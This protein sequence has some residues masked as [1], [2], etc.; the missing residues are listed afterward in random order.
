MEP[1]S[2]PQE[3]IYQPECLA[4]FNGV[5]WIN[6]CDVLNE[7]FF[8]LP[9]PHELGGSADYSIIVPTNDGISY[10]EGGEYDCAEASTFPSSCSSLYSDDETK[11]YFSNEPEELVPLIGLPAEDKT[12]MGADFGNHHI[13][14]SP[15][16][17]LTADEVDRWMAE[18]SKWLDSVCQV[19]WHRANII[20]GHQA[21][22]KTLENQVDNLR[23]RLEQ[24][25]RSLYHHD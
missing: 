19:I 13:S 5:E 20:N 3:Q 8:A 24:V 1:I 23:T 14:S 17:T 12:S 16:H 11:Y 15:P 10:N 22:L 25:E 4:N 6:D 7:N 21:T 18:M 9:N 2:C